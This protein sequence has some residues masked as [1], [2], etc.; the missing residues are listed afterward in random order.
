MSCRWT[1]RS[2]PP[3][4]GDRARGPDCVAR[5][6]SSGTGSRGSEGGAGQRPLPHARPHR[7]A[8][9]PPARDLRL[10][11]AAGITTVRNMWGHEEV[12]QLQR[13]VATGVR[14]GPTIYSASPGLDGTPPSG[15]APCRSW[16]RPP[17]E[18]RCGRRWRPAGR[19]SR[20]IRSS[21]RPRITPSWPPRARPA[22]RSWGMCRYG[23][24]STTRSR[25]AS[26]PSSI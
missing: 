22:S 21:R 13:D 1:G 20:C 23:W 2:S 19:G 5:S 17:R 8:C 26:G 10:Y 25:R 14:R 7:H 9:A 12:Q 6:C 15:P 16:T 18:T 4:D 11:L 24:T 3:P